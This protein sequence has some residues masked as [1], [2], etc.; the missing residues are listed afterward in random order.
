MR[1]DKQ[2]NMPPD[3][4]VLITGARA[5]VALEWAVQFRAAGWRVLVADAM[6]RPLASWSKSVERKWHVPPPR[7]EPEAFVR[8]IARI[9]RE[10]NVHLVVPVCEEIF[11]LAKH[12]EFLPKTTLLWADSVE[13]LRR[14]HDKSAF[15]AWSQELGLRVPETR[16]LISADE[17][18][19]LSGDCWLK[20]CFGRF[21]ISGRR[22]RSGRTSGSD[23][24][25]LDRQEISARRPWVAQEFL[26]GN[27]WC[28]TALAENGRL[29]AQVSYPVEWT[30]GA[31]ACVFFRAVPHPEIAEWVIRFVE[32]SHFTGQIAFDFIDVPGMGALPVEC[33]PRGTS[34]L[35]LLP[36]AVSVITGRISS[37]RAGTVSVGTGAGRLSLPMVIF[38]LPQAILRRKTKDWLQDW[39]LGKE[40]T[41]PV[42]DFGPGVIG[43][44]WMLGWLTGQSLRLR[45]GLTAASTENLEWNG[46]ESSC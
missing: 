36:E 24:R 20:P 25:W 39:R 4:T 23:V 11:A 21:S 5:P 7:W 26:S 30:A 40:V 41:W 17:V 14:L 16:R 37:A 3:R 46:P 15:P 28:A 35:H 38:G 29:L 12:R 18:R 6:P 13:N 19:E 22:W 2:G 34:G 44:L 33:N 32:G 9:C 10:E 8:E 42:G 31:G 43:N 1:F 45:C 27:G